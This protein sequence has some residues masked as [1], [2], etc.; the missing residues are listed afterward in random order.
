[1]VTV[2]FLPEDVSVQV[3]EGTLLLDAA[4][5]TGVAIE[6]P[7]GGQ[8]RCGRCRLKVERGEVTHREN[9]HLTQDQMEEGWVLACVAR[10]AADLVVSVP[11]QEER[12]KVAVATAASRSAVPI[13][14]DWPLNPAVRRYYLEIPPP[15]LDDNAP[16][17]ERLRRVLEREHNV[18]QFSVRLPM[19]QQ[20]P[21]ILREAD[22][23][24]TATLESRDATGERYLI[25]LIPGRVREANLGAA[26]DVGTTTVVIYLV[27]L[28]TGRLLDRASAF[29][30]Q[31]SR[32]ADIIS[33]IIYSQ[34]PDGLAELQHLLVATINDVLAEL[35][36]R[37]HFRPQDINDM[38]IAGNTTM[39]HLLLG[40]PTRQIR[41]EPYIPVASHFPVLPAREVGIDINPCASVCCMPAVAAY[42]GGDITAGVLSSGLYKTRKLS[43]FL[44]IGTN[45]EIVMGNADW[46]MACACSA[47]PAFEGAGV[48]SGMRAVEGAI[49][50]VRIHSETLEPTIQVIGQV[51]PRGIC[52]SGMISA[53]A[54][55]LVTGV[56]DKSGHIDV[57]YVNRQTGERSRARI[58]EH[59]AEYV[60][61]WAK[62]TSIGEDIVLMEVD[63]DNLIRTKAAIYA[64]MTVMAKSVGIQMSDIEEV[65]IGGAF[66]QHIN[67]EEAIQIGL[68]PDLPWEKFRYLGN[69]SAWGAFEVLL[70]RPARAKAEEI[71]RK[72]TYL[73]LV[74]DNR[75]MNEFT[76]ALFLP[77]TELASFPS[78]RRLLET[79][80]RGAGIH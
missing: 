41:E 74:A 61:A 6:I 5:K 39:I 71:A 79:V 1:M 63:I 3:P 21:S 72:I 28:R 40:L 48:H 70:S 46:M 22:W 18:P 25:Q 44:D 51:P 65:L 54:E 32:G 43:L 50:D 80:G 20:I 33:R 68:F 27:D 64:G 57:E 49:E 7:C 31:I 37:N 47:G 36:Q 26:V 34:R 11:P 76:S 35:A 15:S 59:G 12:E 13:R 14:S 75:F 4:S 77:H 55:M 52:G 42:V 2:T 69:T 66:G 19:L 8:G 30:K 17:L 53:M 45:G 9:P 78:V 73:E 16:D 23:K 60:I 56:V 24:V 67:V 62:D 38:V 29:N 58:G 10:A